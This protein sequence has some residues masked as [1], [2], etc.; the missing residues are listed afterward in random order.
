MKRRKFT[1]VLG[2]GAAKGLAHIGVLDALE[3]LELKPSLIVGCSMGSLVGAVYAAGIPLRE[4]KKIALRMT[5]A[6]VA[7]FFRPKPSI[8][9]LTDGLPV[10]NFIESI[11]GKR[12]AENLPIPFAAVAVDLTTGQEYILRKG[13]VTLIVRASISVPGIF[14]PVPWDGLLLIDGGVADPVPVEVAKILSDD[15]VIAVNVLTS[16]LPP[17]QEFEGEIETSPH[18]KN[19]SKDINLF[20]IALHTLMIMES[21][22]I[23]DRLARFPPDVLIEPDVGD[24]KVY[25][26][27]RAK[28]AIGKGFEATWEK[29]EEILEKL[30]F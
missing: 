8:S 15:P 12:D 11:I 3:A 14:T 9:G 28:D 25:E 19:S 29:R 4:I 30:Q 6:R 10:I 24:I 27:Y 5:K 18:D 17:L 21:A 7:Q 13:S 20:Y 1:L 16:P 2:G 23:R 26:F 22:L